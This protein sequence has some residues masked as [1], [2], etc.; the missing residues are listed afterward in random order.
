MGLVGRQFGL[1]T[2]VVGSVVGRFMSRS[3]AA[4]NRWVVSVVAQEAPGAR[5]VLE[6]GSGPGVGL[7]ALLDRFPDARIT[8]ADPSAAMHAQALR[9]HRRAVTAGR[10][11]LVRGDLGA[12]ADLAPFDVVMAVHVLYFWSDPVGQLVE[13]RG[14]LAPGGLIAL[15][16]RLRPDMPAA[17]QRDFPATGHRLYE[18]DDDVL[19]VFVAAGFAPADVR[20]VTETGGPGGRVAL[21]IRR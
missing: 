7:S 6:L 13:V 17:A 1:P 3:N 18:T 4:F 2:G 12:A 9:R 15:G 21:G 14:A 10:L 11:D 5:R 19:A 16:Y 8:G 20:V